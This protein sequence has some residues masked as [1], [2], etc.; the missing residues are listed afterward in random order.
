LL[1]C[2]F[3]GRRPPALPDIVPLWTDH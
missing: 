3:E 1:R 2:F